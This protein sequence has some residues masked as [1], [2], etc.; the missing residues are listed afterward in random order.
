MP[1]QSAADGWWLVVQHGT[2]IRSRGA[3]GWGCGVV[4][5]GCGVVGRPVCRVMK[6][7]RPVRPRSRWPCPTSSPSSCPTAS[8]TATSC[9]ATMPG[10]LCPRG[11]PITRCPCGNLLPPRLTSMRPVSLFSSSVRARRVVTRAVRV[12]ELPG[13]RAHSVC[14]RRA[15]GTLFTSRLCPRHACRP[16]Q[17]APQSEPL[18]LHA[19]QSACPQHAAESAARRGDFAEAEKLQA[20]RG[21]FAAAVG[22]KM[23]G[24]IFCTARVASD[25]FAGRGGAFSPFR[26]AGAA[27]WQGSRR[28][29]ARRGSSQ[30]PRTP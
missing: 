3:V 29:D 23:I 1:R 15:L 14:Q 20:D 27:R 6:I 8:T 18:T 2:L 10:C 11:P 30:L 25:A 24:P 5:W 4:G 17:P 16:A 21:G 19:R 9:P 26:A 12:R 28:F 13:P 7:L 22:E